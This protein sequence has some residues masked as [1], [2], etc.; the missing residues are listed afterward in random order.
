VGVRRLL[1]E[2]AVENVLASD[3]EDLRRERRDTAW[4]GEALPG[5]ESA[6]EDALEEEGEQGDAIAGAENAVV[7]E[8]SLPPGMH[9]R[10]G[11]SLEED[12]LGARPHEDM[13]GARPQEESEGITE[14]SRKDSSAV[15]LV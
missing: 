2:G 6:G 10:L 5:E 14:L 4:T 15:L 11:P 9:D 13:L 8:L 7:R 12:M 3:S 1:S